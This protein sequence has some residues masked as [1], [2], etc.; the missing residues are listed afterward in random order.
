MLFSKK[1]TKN[2]TKTTWPR[3]GKAKFTENDGNSAKR[4]LLQGKQLSNEED[5]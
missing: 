5:I 1:Y 4:A 3:I 2:L